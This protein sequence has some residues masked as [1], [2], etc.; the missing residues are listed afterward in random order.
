MR[1][2]TVIT[3]YSFVVLV[4]GF[5]ILGLGFA[6]GDIE[7]LSEFQG[8]EKFTFVVKGIGVV[9]LLTGFAGLGWAY[10]LTENPKLPGYAG[11]NGPGLVIFL[12]L[13]L[14]IGPLAALLAWALW[15][16][17]MFRAEY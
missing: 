3:L 17:P 15:L 10:F 12:T 11:L 6:F 7:A 2:R 14:V 13:L 9:L 16:I 8:S 5:L 1:K 4:T